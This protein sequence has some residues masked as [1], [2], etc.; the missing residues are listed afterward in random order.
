MKI[1]RRRFLGLIGAAA[2]S[3]VLGYLGFNYLLPKKRQLKVYNYSYYID[4]KVIDK[5]EELYNVEVIYDEY[6]AAEEA[7]AKIQLGGGGYDLIVLT[8]SY[9]PQAIKQGLLQPIDH[10]L[11]PNIAN[12]EPKFFDNPFDPSFKYAVPYMW[13]TTGIGINTKY[14]KEGE[15]E[16]YEQLFDTETFLPQHQGKVSMLEEFIEVIDAAKLYLGVSLDD[17]S[18]KI[19][20]EVI[21]LLKAQKP[22]LYGYVG[23]SVYVP[24]LVSGS[25]HAAQAWS[26]DVLTAQEEEES[27]QY[28]V[29][30]EGT[31]TWFDFM[32]IPKKS[33]AV[34]LAHAWINFMLEPDIAAA[35][36]EYVYYPNPLKRSLVESYLSEEVL[37]NPAIYP[38]KG[39]ELF[40]PPLMTEEVLRIVERISTEV[41]SA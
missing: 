5:F 25:L 11:V 22:Y 2:A 21:D 18:E 27:V 23:A 30:K 28:V 6:E 8:D 3:A 4:P 29:P 31:W 35:N 39:I 9:V 16:G 37:E 33:K 12:I 20:E 10:S 14:I 7:Y 34:D 24:S 41:K 36:T 26:G 19:V 17:W 13:G 1:T 40:T 38:P 32:V 15:V